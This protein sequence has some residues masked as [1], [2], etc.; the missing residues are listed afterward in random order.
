MGVPSSKPIFF[1]EKGKPITELSSEAGEAGKEG[2]PGEAGKEGAPGEGAPGEGAPGEGAPDEGA[3]GDA[4]PG[5]ATPESEKAIG[6]IKKNNMK[7]WKPYLESIF[8]LDDL[9]K[10]IEVFALAQKSET[11]SPEDAEYIKKKIIVEGSDIYKFAKGD[12]GFDKDLMEYIDKELFFKPELKKMAE[13]TSEGDKDTKKLKKDTKSDAIMPIYDSVI[14]AA[15]IARHRH[16]LLEVVNYVKDS[17]EFK[18]KYKELHILSTDE[19]AAHKGDQTAAPAEPAPAETA[20]PVAAPE[21]SGGD[22]DN[23]SVSSYGGSIDSDSSGTASFSGGFKVFKNA[24]EKLAAREASDAKD[25]YKKMKEGK[26]KDIE[27]KK[28]QFLNDIIAYNKFIDENKD[29]LMKIYEPSKIGVNINKKAPEIATVAEALIKTMTEYAPTDDKT[30]AAGTAPAADKAAPPAGD[31]EAP[32]EDKGLQGESSTDPP[33]EGEST[34]GGAIMQGGSAKKKK[35]YT[36]KKKPQRISININVGNENV[37]SDT[38]SSSSS[39]SS[40]SDTSS[41][42][43]DE[44]IVRRKKKKHHKKNL[45]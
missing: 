15:K 31:K 21:K 28:K 39:D 3:P 18:A 16:A 34:A 11:A 36:K 5:D 24:D 25:A 7:M 33:P 37:I 6:E 10:K 19:A 12:K 9:K 4:T 2:K 1:D 8:K 40:S 44:K 29:N 20:A 14:A 41:D 42:D 43:E 27:E 32:A 22:G 38:S 45:P 23:S 17:D 26:E 13:E 35:R 30:G